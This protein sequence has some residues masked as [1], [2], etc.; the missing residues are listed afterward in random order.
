MTVYANYGDKANNGIISASGILCDYGIL[1]PGRTDESGRKPYVDTV[2]CLALLYW[3]GDSF[4][5]IEYGDTRVMG[6]NTGT[7]RYV[8]CSLSEQSAVTALWEGA[9]PTGT[10]KACFSTGGPLVQFIGVW[11]KIKDAE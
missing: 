9:V 6:I 11:Q 3:E 4:R 2:G 1:S 7:L 5:Q 8:Y 10:W